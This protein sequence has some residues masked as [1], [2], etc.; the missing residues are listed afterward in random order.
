MKVVQNFLA[1]LSGT[2]FMYVSVRTMPRASHRGTS[3]RDLK[4]KSKVY[5]GAKAI[6]VMGLHRADRMGVICW[7]RA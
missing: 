3:K 1:T 6:C 4:L 7:D 5:Q 2:E